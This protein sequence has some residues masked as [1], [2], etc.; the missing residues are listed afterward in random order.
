MGFMMEENTTVYYRTFRRAS[1]R[2]VPAKRNDVE[3]RLE[4]SMSAMSVGREELECRFLKQK[5]REQ[6]G[7]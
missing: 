7:R 1:K 6:T 4:K 5:G 3:D 2:R